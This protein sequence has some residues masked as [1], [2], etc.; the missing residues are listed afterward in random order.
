[1]V[2]YGLTRAYR[3]S[4][5]FSSTSHQPCRFTHSRNRLPSFCPEFGENH[6]RKVHQTNTFYRNSRHHFPSSLLIPEFFVVHKCNPQP[7]EMTRN[8]TYTSIFS[9]PDIYFRKKKRN[10][11]IIRLELPE[12]TI[13]HVTYMERYHHLCSLMVIQL[14]NFFSFLVFVFVHS[15]FLSRLFFSHPKLVL[16]SLNQNSF[17]VYMVEAR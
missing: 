12:L 7:I 14:F 2:S 8:E 13:T 15:L 5:K 10:V 11:T 16:C 17:L 3:T 6:I 4:A 9:W 1:M